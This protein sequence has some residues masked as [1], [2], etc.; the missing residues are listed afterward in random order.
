[1]DQRESTQTE[2][3]KRF[4]ERAEF[5]VTD[6]MHVSSILIEQLIARYHQINHIQRGF[7][8]VVFSLSCL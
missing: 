5:L 7:S 4:I 6:F 1:M 3:Q 8:I 2:N